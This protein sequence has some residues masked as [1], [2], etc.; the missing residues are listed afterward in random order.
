MAHNRIITPADEDR[1]TMSHGFFTL[2]SLSV[3]WR[4]NNGIRN[5]FE[6]VKHEYILGKLNRVTFVVKL[7]VLNQIIL[8]P[9]LKGL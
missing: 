5:I 7:Q 2:Q 9:Q 8:V 4:I 1:M 3:R 6:G